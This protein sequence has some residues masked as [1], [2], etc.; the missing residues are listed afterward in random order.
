MRKAFGWM[1]FIF[2]VGYVAAPWKVV[3]GQSASTPS[4]IL[5]WTPSTSTSTTEQ[6]VYRATS[7]SGPWTAIATISNN[8]T[9]SYTDTTGVVGTTYFYEVDAL[10]IAGNI[11]AQSGPSNVASAAS[12]ANPNPPMGLAAVGN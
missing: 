3:F 4:V 2:V 11:D 1:L 12:V 9:N 8:T 6:I 7:S 10:D 5:S